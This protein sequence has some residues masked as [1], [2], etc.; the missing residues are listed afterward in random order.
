MVQLLESPA[1]AER[2]AAAAQFLDSIAPGTEVLIVGPSRAAVDDLV[3]T[4]SGHRT[5]T[6]GW[7]RFTLTQLA[8]RLAAPALSAGALAP[9]TTLAAEAV[10]TR[11]TFEALRAERIP[12]FAPVARYPGFG[13]TLAATVSELRAAGVGPSHL[14]ALGQPSDQLA[15]LLEGYE[16]QLRSAQLADR[17]VLLQA[18]TAAVDA[19]PIT[20][21]PLLLL[22]VAVSDAVERALVEALC[23]RSPKALI[24]RPAE[25]ERTRR[26]LA[27]IQTI[28]LPR[29]PLPAAA[30]SL[31]RLQNYLFAEQPP[32]GALDD[33]V[34]FFSAPGE[35]RETVEI[36]RWILTE[37]RAGT[38]FD[39]MA[40]FLRSP[41]TYGALLETA[42][43]R[44]G[45]PAYFTRGTRRPNPSGR[46]FLA[47]LAC[48]AE[49]LSATR[50]AEYLS[51]GHIP[52]PQHDTPA[53]DAAL[54]WV[55]PR[56]DA[57]GA[58]STAA[59]DA[60]DAQDSGDDVE[61]EQET[62]S[63]APWKWESLL[64]DAA[65][66]GGV[67]RWRRRLDGLDRELDLR[68][69]ELEGDEPDA[70]RRAALA[71][72][73]ASLADLRRFALPI[74][75]RLAALPPRAPWGE[76][77]AHLSALAPLAVSQ[78]EPILQAI[79]ELA[80]MAAV[81]PVAIDEVREVL[82]NR[83]RFVT[84]EP[85]AYRYGRVLVTTLD[86]ARARSLQIVFVPGLAER[87][88]PR[89]PREDPLLLDA[90]RRQLSG[91]LLTQT[92]RGQHERLL[93][94]LAVGA[95]QRRIYLSYPRVDVVQAR[96][97]VT[98]FYGLDVVRAVAGRIPDVEV[99][100][101]EAEAVVGARLAWP[102]PSDPAQ[103]IDTSEHDLAV[104]GGLIHSGTVPPEKGGAQYLLHLNAHLGRSLRTRYGRWE[105]KQWSAY[106]GFIEPTPPAAALLA[107]HRL[108]A[109]PYSLSALQQYAVCPYRFFLAAIQ[110]LAPRA[111]VAALEQL[112][113]LT[114]GR[115]VHRVQ[116]ETLRTLADSGGLPVTAE[117]LPRAETT[118]LAT[119]ERV[120]EH[121][122]DDLAP[123]ILR[124]WQDEMEGVRADL[125]Y[126]LR[127]LAEQG[128]KWQ[129]AFFEF[130]FGLP[131]DA[132]RDP[133]SRPD[134]VMLD[135]GMQ[136]R[137]AVDLIERRADGR[138]LRVTDHKTGADRTES[139]LVIGK[140]EVL[141]PVLYGLVVEAA[142]NQP[143]V[144]GR[145]FYCTARGGFAER[146]VT[147]DDRARRA[148]LEALDT[149]DQAIANGFLPP[150][151]RSGAC[152]RCDFRL[153]CGPY[154]EERWPKSK[155][156][157]RLAALEALRQ[158]P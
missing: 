76:W 101:R 133:N 13:R 86:D 21:L 69:A 118:L 39:Q 148:G 53:T 23:A 152:V 150:A 92:E 36:A 130:G 95:A 113:P 94:R 79:A 27:S 34:S 96:P 16:I 126:W 47:L 66:I 56:D 73:R 102:A 49:G 116:A 80:P 1:A 24:T 28:A 144:E 10:A 75:E 61:D 138:A 100:Q 120:G 55:G 151:P 2:L 139:G 154:E 35:S 127:R 6:F 97:R 42:L 141:Q 110:Q 68:S 77:L 74:I 38:P 112:D 128:E 81:G 8:A 143:V 18:A 105:R 123:P 153:V 32:E 50:F 52:A 57:L 125:V 45:I 109:R 44:A 85:P 131:S 99:F 9:C 62:A 135:N 64:V 72:T 31:A 83:L 22:D 7:H 93:L 37:A 19:D 67:D 91:D 11:A 155:D 136:L 3:R 121:L 71:R 17:T 137:G 15:L 43:R 29:R 140:G 70:P 108:T 59:A 149:V 158:R 30:P 132:T 145:L 14:A 98:S 82:G 142:L 124:V 20:G 107:D 134:P 122:Y 89:R 87:V 40:V 156:L 88:L 104:L 65:V 90:L 129:P 111:E 119:L 115:L 78:P 5:A 25:D 41:E 26:F 63:V 103:A 58:A 51:F 114:R 46:A 106:D 147:L 157:T 84:D 54:S 12:F 33:S 117:T 4:L 48:A 146:S 60:A